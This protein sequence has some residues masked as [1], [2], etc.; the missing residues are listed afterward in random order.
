MVG[1]CAITEDGGL[2]KRIVAHAGEMLATGS[3]TGAH[4]GPV[5]QWK[6]IKRAAYTVPGTDNESS[7]SEVDESGNVF[8][9]NDTL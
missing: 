1:G 7:D 9:G 5:S 4:C 8:F 3:T 2:F 6:E